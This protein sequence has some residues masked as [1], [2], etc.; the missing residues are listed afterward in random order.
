MRNQ[1][2][3]EQLCS[4]SF[5]EVGSSVGSMAGLGTRSGGREGRE[6]SVREREKSVH[7]V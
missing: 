7:H 1:G 2:W 3:Y 5:G 4:F 6:G